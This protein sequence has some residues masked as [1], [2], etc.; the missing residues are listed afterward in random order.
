MAWWKSEFGAFRL[1]MQAYKKLLCYD[2]DDDD[3]NDHNNNNQYKIF[4]I[5]YIEHV[6]LD[7]DHTRK[8]ISSTFI[9]KATSFVCHQRQFLD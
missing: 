6:F 7:F 1:K 2:D 8:N 3:D 9:P 4:V 5:R